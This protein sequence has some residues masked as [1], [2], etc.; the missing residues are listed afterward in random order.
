ML[1]RYVWKVSN[2]TKCSSLCNGGSQNRTV[3][4]RGVLVDRQVNST[5]CTAERPEKQQICNDQPCPAEWIVGNWTQV[6]RVFLR[7]VYMEVGDPRWVR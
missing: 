4:C 1:Y 2:W 7:P 5:L 3:E 6:R